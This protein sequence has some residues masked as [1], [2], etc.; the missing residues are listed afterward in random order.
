MPACASLG[1]AVIGLGIG[2]QHARAYQRLGNCTLRW[3]YDLDAQRMSSVLARLGQGQAA[4]RLQTILDDA[5][6]HVVSVASYDA[7]HYEQVLAALHAGKHVFV[8]KP[9]CRSVAE[10][11]AIKQAWQTGAPLHLAS[12]LVLRAAPLY[13]WLKRLIAAGEL[14]DIYA[15]DG[16]YLY[17][18]LE[19]ITAGWRKGQEHYSVMQG[20]GIH[21]VDLLLWLTGQRPTA[22]SAVGTRLCTAHTA[23]R[24]NDF[25]AATLQFPSGLIG[26][27]TANFGCVH[28][29]QHVLRVFGTRG[30]FIY[31]DCQARWHRSRDPAQPPLPLAH[32]SLPSCKGALIPAFI[33]AITQRTDRSAQTQHEFDVISVCVAADAAC[34]H[35][36]P[37]PVIYV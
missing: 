9:L 3:V 13:Q 33:Q 14:G 18:R 37:V 11:R 25:M 17:G 22:V 4:T 20:G 26:R 2:E 31:D 19:K 32:S 16:D 30:T 8:E 5:A 10:L 28:R 35:G 6:V 21:L 1:A 34:A 7:A 36:T 15:I 24:Y 27:I 12:N 29:H 23:F